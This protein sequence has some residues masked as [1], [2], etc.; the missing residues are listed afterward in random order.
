MCWEFFFLI[1]YSLWSILYTTGVIVRRKFFVYTI[2]PPF[3]GTLPSQETETQPMPFRMNSE[4]SFVLTLSFSSVL[5]MEATFSLFS[6]VSS[7]QCVSE[8]TDTVELF[9]LYLGYSSSECPAVI[10]CHPF[11]R[12]PVSAPLDFVA[13]GL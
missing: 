4:L 2:V 6:L 1:L 7:S 11:I 8:Q 5:V 13:L 10:Y 12:S 3:A 9:L